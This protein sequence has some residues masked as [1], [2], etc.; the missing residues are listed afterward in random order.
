MRLPRLHRTED[1]YYT[2]FWRSLE[3]GNDFNCELLP[4]CQA[5][6]S[7]ISLHT[8]DITANK[9]GKETTKWM[10]S[11]QQHGLWIASAPRTCSLT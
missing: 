8:G 1:D 3:F 7:M 2:A 4:A 6:L 9:T 10:V 5:E 11:M